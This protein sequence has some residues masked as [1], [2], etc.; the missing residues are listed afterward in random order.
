VRV[1]AARGQQGT[2]TPAANA[3]GSATVTVTAKDNGGA[4]DRGRGGWAV[5]ERH[6]RERHDQPDRRRR[7]QRGQQ[8]DPDGQLVEHQAGAEQWDRDRRERGQPHADDHGRIAV[9]VD[10]FIDRIMA[11]RLSITGACPRR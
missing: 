2:D 11:V 6:Q 9:V 7:G 10:D 8:P 5:P 1:R 4:D 3:N